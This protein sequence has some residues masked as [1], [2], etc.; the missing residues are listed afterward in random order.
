MSVE[1]PPAAPIDPTAQ[2]HLDAFRAEL[3]G[4]VLESVIQHNDVIVRVRLDAWVDAAAAC[5]KIG[6]TYFC[7][8]AGL[9]WLDSP[10]Q[11]TRYENV[12]GSVEDETVEPV[13]ASR[14]ADASEAGTPGDAGKAPAE[15]VAVAE[16]PEAASAADPGLATGLAGGTSR[17]QVFA[18]FYS[19]TTHRA[20]IVKADLDDA[21]PMVPTITKV[22]A[23]AD[24]H[25]RET[26]EMYGFWF[27]GHP[28]LVHLYLPMGFEGYP[29]RK[30]FPLLAREVKPWPGLTNV[31]PIAGEADEEGADA[32]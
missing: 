2:Q 30:D 29:M 21:N 31:E 18:R 13:D 16:V 8:L 23:G 14:A 26:W 3:G 10:L 25:E 17:F 28:H 32:S 9:D 11:T 4:A 20:I 1:A 5:K 6:L 24:W 27:E 19:T 15:S 12:W 22:F 7:F